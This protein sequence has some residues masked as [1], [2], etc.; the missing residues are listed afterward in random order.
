MSVFIAGE[1][2]KPLHTVRC[3]CGELPL[4][5]SGP[6]G[7]SL[8]CSCG[9]KVEALPFAQVPELIHAWNDLYTMGVNHAD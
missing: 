3:H 2:N 5:V 8:E 9:I 4:L 1:T 7:A 6:D